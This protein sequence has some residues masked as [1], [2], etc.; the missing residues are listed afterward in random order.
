MP[1]GRQEQKAENSLLGPQARSRG[2]GMEMIRAFNLKLES[3]DVIPSPNS[4]SIW[5]PSDQMSEIAGDIS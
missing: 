1:S 3:S 2:S 5:G 4:S